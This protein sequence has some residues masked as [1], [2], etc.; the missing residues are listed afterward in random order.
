MSITANPGNNITA[1]TSV[2]FTATPTNGGATPAY[3]WKKNNTNVGAN[4]PTYM[5][6]TLANGD[7][8]TVVMTS[9]DPCASPATATSNS[10]TMTVTSSCILPTVF[11]V[12]GGEWYCPGVGGSEVGLSDSELG[13]NYQ[14]QNFSVNVGSA[15]PGTGSALSFGTF[16]SG[17]YTVVATNVG[18][19]CTIDMNGVKNFGEYFQSFFYIGEQHNCGEDV[20][21]VYESEGGQ[22]APY[23]WSTN[24]TTQSITVNQSGTYTVTATDLNGC[25]G[26]ASANVVVS[27][28]V[29]PSVSISANPGN[30]IT[31]G[32]PVTFTA[33]P[34]NGGTTPTYQWKKNNVNVGAN[35]PTYMDNALANGDVITVV[36]TSSDPCASPATATSDAITMTVTPCVSAD[37]PMFSG[38][39]ATYCDLDAPVTL[40]GNLPGSDAYFDGPGITNH[41]DGTATFTPADAIGSGTVRYLSTA[42]DC[43]EWMAATAGQDHSVALKRDGTLWAWGDNTYGQLGNGTNTREQIPVQIGT[44]NDWAAIASGIYHT[45]AI[46][47][48]GTLWAWGLG[49]SGQLGNGTFTNSNI[50]VQIGTDND[51]VSIRSKGYFTIALKSNGTLWAW[52]S[53]FFGQLGNGTNINSGVPVQAGTDTDWAAI[54]AGFGHTLA[55]KTNGTLW[56]WGYNNFGQTGNSANTPAQ[57]G[58]DTDWDKIFAG[59]AQSYA[60][61]T[62]GTLWSWGR[63]SNGQLGI[64]NNT[65]TN[66]P[67]QVGSD[68]DWETMVASDACLALKS[69]GALW[70]WGTNGIGQLG[71]GNNTDTNT[72]AQIGTATDWTAIGIGSA[73]TLAVNSGGFLFTTGA[74][75]AAQLG[76]ATVVSKNQFGKVV[77][78]FASSQVTVD[79][80]LAFDGLDPVYCSGDE[81]ATLTGN[82][83]P[84]G[85]FSGPGITDNGN[86]TA[87]FDPAAAGTGGTVT[88]EY[89]TGLPWKKVSAGYYHTLGIK[90]DGTLWGWGYE[91]YGSIGNSGDD[92]SNVPLQVG[93]DTDWADVSAG[94]YHSLGV[95]T[96][97]TLWAWGNNGAGQLGIGNTTNQNI[98]VQVGA[99]TDWAYVE[100]GDGR[101]F[102]IKTDG[103]LWAWGANGG[104]PGP[105]SNPAALTPVQIGT[106]TNWASVST[107]TYLG[108]ALAIKTDGTLWAWGYNNSGQ[109]GTGNNNNSN[110][111]VQVGT[112]TDWQ[113]AD[114]GYRASL[115]IKTDGTLWAWGENGDGQ[116]GNGSTSDSNIPVLISNG[117]ACVAAGYEYS[118]GVKTDGTLW[119]WGYNGDGNLGNGTE[120]DSNVPVQSGTATNWSKVYATVD[121]YFSFALNQ[122]GNLFGFGGNGDGYL[123]DGTY[124]DS[125]TPVPV[126]VDEPSAF[127][128]TSR[129]V[130]VNPLPTATITGTAT[131]CGSLS[132]TASGG[133][134][135]VWSG[136]ST[137]NQAANTFTASG[138]Y[139]VTVTGANGCT[140]TAS[141]I[142]TVNPA[143]TATITGTATACG[144]L[145]LTASG[146]TSFVWSGGS[147]PNQAANT[148][149]AS[150]TYTVTVT[151]ANGCTATASQI[152]TVN[153][154]PTATITGTATACGSLS[155]TA[156]GGTS[157]VWSGG[158]TPNQAANTFTASGTYTV[159]VTGAN[160][161]TATAS[162]I[163]TVNAAPTATITG[164]SSGTGSITLTASGGN[165]YVWSG[166]ST[167]NQAVNTFTASGTYTVTVTSINGCTASASKSITITTPPITG[168]TSVC[169]GQP[170]TLT[171]SGGG[172]YAFIGPLGLKRANSTVPTWSITPTSTSFTGTYSVII[173]GGSNPGTYSIFV[174]VNALPPTPTITGNSLVCS[175]SNIVLTATA[176]GGT[177]YSW[178]GPLGYTATGATMSRGP[179]SSTMSGSYVVTVTN[180]AGCTKSASKSVTVT[181]CKTGEITTAVDLSAYPNPTN[182][183]T[184]VTFTGYNAQKTVLAVYDVMGRAVTVLFEGM[185]EENTVYELPFNTA[186][187]PP[188]TYYAVLQTENGDRQQIRLLVMH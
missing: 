127:A 18:S 63:N 123:G 5:D 3:Q 11:D 45:V 177:A 155:L 71:N 72:P 179:A 182:G 68:T 25:T 103:S 187:L 135:F 131:A 41:G 73:H 125:S 120:D 176:T 8:I 19:G 140:A 107:F 128:T 12:T 147:T 101:S 104:V 58:T 153:P 111:P 61:K 90:A 88:Y 79:I 74:N 170:F 94:A 168:P 158:S 97:G 32:P 51:W 26:T 22:Q 99:A 154:A 163:V 178:S 82:H 172:T 36:M 67:T 27:A 85:T 55:I 2:T 108:H 91:Y 143:P 145:S 23:L 134:S 6:N 117:W 13:V 121:E 15:V 167:P 69:N 174:T 142:V 81:P 21:T 141:Q 144:S 46:K 102:G 119:G 157:F 75:S 44:D 183:E 54:A 149:T 133:T 34:T 152:V 4:S 185:T 52:G 175:G 49:S 136:G 42:I 105:G 83:A 139:T 35:S 30:N 162:Q 129:I 98:P 96:D 184:M 146:G 106:E 186:L 112:D 24:E 39:G 76:N 57:I 126:Q 38:L 110:V 33:T 53:N 20:L 159:T 181:T 166:G 100:A 60:I 48:N 28:L 43:P 40:T 122:D 86:G 31:A 164:P 7:V 109:L 65:S 37:L 171:A 132:L 114:A 80:C 180:A 151:G 118:L 161:C 10:I 173:T 160:G 93:T 66:T 77:S 64:G 16:T 70:G 87:T 50:P 150:G 116:L 137:P 165:T 124:D 156:S 78:A 130:T 62:N 9:S 89:Y 95:K 115:A 56:A 188:G 47:T 138:T 59:S 148:F 113:K 1:G 17:Q 29:T 14:L 169:V 92:D 84:D